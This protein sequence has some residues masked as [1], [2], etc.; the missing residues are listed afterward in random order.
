MEHIFFWIAIVSGLVILGWAIFSLAAGSVVYFSFLTTDHAGLETKKMAEAESGS[1]LQNHTRDPSVMNPINA[2]KDR[3]YT[4]RDRHEFDELVIRSRDGLA[5]AG[6]FWRADT[7]APAGGNTVIIVHGMYDSSAGMGYLSEE[8]HAAGWNVLCI[9]QRSHGESEGTTRTMGV[10]EAEDIGLWVSELETRYGSARIVV[11]GV[12]MGG[13]A[14]LLYAGR[15][16]GLP[17]SVIGAVSDASYAGY[18]E[19]FSYVLRKAVPGDF[20]VRSIIAGASAASFFHS[21]VRFGNMSPIRIIDRIPVPLLLFHG[22]QDVL[23][24]VSMVRNMYAI[25]KE[26]GAEAIIVPDA[27]HIGAYFYARDLYM[28]KIF[29]LFGR[30]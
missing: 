29:S 3:W 16:G 14:V 1:V 9:D 8:Y 27:P 22:Q 6:F 26:R 18:S 24:P 21:G 25:A 2:A 10:R 13:A 5:L 15:L 7:H 20:L 30:S 28:T 19:V 17:R 4:R 12:S 23:V 11:H